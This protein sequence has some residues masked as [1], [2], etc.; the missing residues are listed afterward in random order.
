MPCP[1]RLPSLSFLS[2]LLFLAACT[3]DPELPATG[4]EGGTEGLLKLTVKPVWQGGPFHKDSVYLAAGGQRIR[5]S[6]LKFYLAPLALEDASGLHQ[7]FNVD[8]FQVASG[9]ET[10]VAAVP[11]GTYHAVHWGL[12]LP[13]DLNHLDLATIPVNAPMGN[14]SGMYWEWATMYKFVIFSGHFDSDPS[15]AGA[16]PFLFDIHTGLDTCYRTRTVPYNLTV[17]ADDTT[18]LTVNVD[19]ARFFTDGSRILDL[20]QGAMWHGDVNFL[21]LPLLAADLQSAALSIT[22]E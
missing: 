7:V 8:L 15:G 3:K 16:P 10:R 20:S 5:I 11:S 9:A 17:T 14:N 6:E 2:A 13:Y 4:A 12:G 19:I 1:L 22:P 21:S 18:R